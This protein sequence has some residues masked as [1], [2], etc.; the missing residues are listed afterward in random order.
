MN[1]ISSAGFR[2]SISPP[3][4]SDDSA[5]DPITTP[6]DPNSLHATAP[7]YR[8]SPLGVHMRQSI[9]AWHKLSFGEGVA[10]WENLVRWYREP[11]DAP[12]TSKGKGKAQQSAADTRIEQSVSLPLWDHIFP[13]MTVTL[14]TL[15]ASGTSK[16][17]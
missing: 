10:W 16:Q 2:A 7:L 1:E 3:S 12:T 13:A 11:A 9:L 5:Y 14:T 15:C 4:P 8:N 17:D 6:L